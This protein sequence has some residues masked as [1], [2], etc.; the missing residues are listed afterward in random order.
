MAPVFQAKGVHEEAKKALKLFRRAVEMETVTVELVR[1]VVVYLRRG[2]NDPKLR[3]EAWAA[4]GHC[5]PPALFVVLTSRAGGAIPSQAATRAATAVAW[6]VSPV[7]G[8]TPAPT[9]R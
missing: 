9:A 8:S 1:R 6:T 4:C 2:E 7:R 5:V 3:F